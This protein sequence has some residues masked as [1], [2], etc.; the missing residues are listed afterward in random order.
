MT[1]I[2]LLKAR[3]DMK[4]HEVTCLDTL[5]DAQNEKIKT[6]EKAL[7]LAI[8]YIERTKGK[9]YHKILNYLSEKV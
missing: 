3:L 4:T 9:D 6:Y 5:K 7:N 2:E 1:E 8:K